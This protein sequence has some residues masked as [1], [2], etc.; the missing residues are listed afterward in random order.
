MS[1]Y[2]SEKEQVEAIKK[3][4]DAN[5]TWLLLGLAV[6][7]SGLFGY[8]YYE[9]YTLR[10]DQDAST[11]FENFLAQVEQKN[12]ELALS[13]GRALIA[14]FPASPYATLS[15]L[16]MARLELDQGNIEAARAEVA[17]AAKNAAMTELG[18]LAELRRTR[19]ALLEGD[20]D[21][22]AASLPDLLKD[23]SLLT[24]ELAGDIQA[25][26]GDLDAAAATYE[27]I[28]ALPKVVAEDRQVIE[29]KLDAIGQ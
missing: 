11:N 3:W 21:T 25:A 29:M 26:Q 24:L 17:W 9:S 2:D 19:L 10:R 8:R 1:D 22:A 12:S 20:I 18:A 23:D 13:T 4:W 14:E 27:R 6:G 7:F 28:L 15:A 16:Q 5:G